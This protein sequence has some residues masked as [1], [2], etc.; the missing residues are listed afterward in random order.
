MD[1]ARSLFIVSHGFETSQTAIAGCLYVMRGLSPLRG[2][3]SWF[4]VPCPG[5]MK[6]A[7]LRTSNLLFILKG[8]NTMANEI[9][10]G[11]NY[12]T[13]DLSTRK[14]VSTKIL[15]EL[16]SDEIKR[17]CYRMQECRPE[18][19][20]QNRENADALLSF[21]YINLNLYND[22]EFQYLNAKITQYSLGLA[23][24]NNND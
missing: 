24:G 9:K 5:C 19:I 11:L 8:E 10:R 4:H 2:Y 15:K 1:K 16:F 22:K 3:G 7:S 20:T 17:L 23:R 14:S 18:Y 21:A 6:R 12:T 13:K